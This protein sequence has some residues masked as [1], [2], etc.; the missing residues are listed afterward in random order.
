MGATHSPWYGASGRGELHRVSEMGGESLWSR[1]E[2]CK[3]A[4]VVCSE[5]SL[6]KL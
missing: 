2:G 5:L 6:Q 4:P 3:E 1:M